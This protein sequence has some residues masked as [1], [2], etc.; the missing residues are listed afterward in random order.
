VHI[1]YAFAEVKEKLP[2]KIG[3]ESLRVDDS[4]SIAQN[5]RIH[6]SVYSKRGTESM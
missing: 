1:A 2:V 3:V 6:N 4:G 5:G